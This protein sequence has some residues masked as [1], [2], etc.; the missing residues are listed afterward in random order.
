MIGSCPNMDSRPPRGPRKTHRTLV[1]LRQLT[2][3][4]SRQDMSAVGSEEFFARTF[5]IV[6]HSIIITQAAVVKRC[7]SSSIIPD[8]HSCCCPP[9]ARTHWA[10][11]C[12]VLSINSGIQ[13]LS[14]QPWCHMSE[15]SNGITFGQGLVLGCVCFFVGVAERPRKLWPYQRSSQ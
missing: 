4:E 15:L 14:V 13:P 9:H 8:R 10:K 12:I 7:K 6:Q 1:G 3:I 11:G 5:D 2:C